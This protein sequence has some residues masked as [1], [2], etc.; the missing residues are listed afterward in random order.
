MKIFLVLFT[1]LLITS[2]LWAVGPVVTE[3]CKVEFPTN[4]EV[5]LAGY[6]LYD[7]ATSGNHTSVIDLGLRSAPI[8]VPCATAGITVEGQHYVAVTAYDTSGN[9]SGKSNEFPFVLDVVVGD[10][11][12]PAVPG[13]PSVKP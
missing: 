6:K 8:S 13:A 5:D 2:P 11:Q 4:A 7:G 1:L 3:T 12:A 9:E 10:T